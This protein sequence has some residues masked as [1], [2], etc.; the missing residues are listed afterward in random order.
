MRPRD[1]ARQDRRLDRAAA[2]RHQ[3]PAVRLRIREVQL[4]ATVAA[5]LYKLIRHRG[6]RADDRRRARSSP[7]R[8]AK[9]CLGRIAARGELKAW[10]FVDRELALDDARSSRA[11][12]PRS[13]AR[14]PGR[15]EG[16]DRHR[17]HAD[18]VRLGP[19]QGPPAAE[20]D[21]ACVAQ[22]REAGGVILGKT[23]TTEFASPWQMGAKNPHDLDAHA[24]RVVVRLGGGGRGFPRAA[25][26]RHPDRRL[27]RAARR[28]TAASG[29]S[30]PRS[31]AS[32][33]AASVT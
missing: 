23:A 13:V 17:R 28:P 1:R 15:R 19:A 5:R 4:M 7:R 22:T 20:K 16:R 32:T 8:Y 24:G 25:R 9:S 3:R 31:T 18:R 29:G 12:P 6:A 21:S 14:H 33:A 10:A 26:L 2:A 30:R 11:E 27:D